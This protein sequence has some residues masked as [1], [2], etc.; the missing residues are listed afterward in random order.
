[1]IGN[2]VAGIT[3]KPLTYQELILTDSPIGFWMLNETSGTVGDDL[4]A[5][6]NDQT[7]YNSPT[8][9]ASTGAAGIPRGITWNG[10]TQA[11]RTSYVSTFNRA[12]SN[13]WSVELWFKTNTTNTYTI[14]TCRDNTGGASGQLVTISMN[15]SGVSG[16]LRADTGDNAGGSI[17]LISDGGWNDNVWHHCVVTATSGGAIRLYVDKVERASSTTSRNTGTPSR[18][19]TGA[20]NLNN[21]TFQDYWAGTSA[22]YAIYNTALTTTQITDH[23]N[24]GI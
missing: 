24:A 23:Y 15:A 5:N 4:T 18:S 1:M 16:R 19:L 10:T 14:C 2:V 6:N 21:T 7:F 13:S 8:L 17:L 11:M 12:S 9:N 20:A 22:A 3:A